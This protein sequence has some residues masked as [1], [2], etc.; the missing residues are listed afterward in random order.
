MPAVKIPVLAAA[1]FTNE[2]NETKVEEIKLKQNED[3]EETVIQYILDASSEDT[4]ADDTNAQYTVVNI[5]DVSAFQNAHTVIEEPKPSSTTRIL[6]TTV[7]EDGTTTLTVA[8]EPDEDTETTPNA[9]MEQ[10]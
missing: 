1:T 4:N 9:D 3:Q 10:I 7:N 8:T 5:S 6:S 2:V